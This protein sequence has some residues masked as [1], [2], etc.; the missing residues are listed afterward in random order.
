MTQHPL[1]RARVSAAAIGKV[2]RM[3]SGSLDDILTELLQNARRAGATTIAVSASSEPGPKIIIADNG[4]GIANPQALLSLGESDW[5][6][7]ATLREDPAGMGFFSLAGR[8]TTIISSTGGE[9]FRLAIPDDGWTGER[10]LCV[11]AA[12]RERG[13]TIVFAASEDWLRHLGGAI[14]RAS[15]YL[16]VAVTLDGVAQARKGFLDGAV[17]VK[18][19]GGLAIGVFPRSFATHEAQIN[20]HGLTIRHR[21]FSLVETDHSHWSA[22]I[23]IIDAPEL[24]L[25]LPARKELVENP[26]SLALDTLVKTAIFE[27]IRER[28]H[29]CLTK[30]D[31]DDAAALG[32]ELP[33]ADSLLTPWQPDMADEY[34]GVAR[35]NP[36]EPASD[37]LLVPC[38]DP[39]DAQMFHRALALAGDPPFAQLLDARPAYQGYRW[40]DALASISDCRA[41][42]SRDGDVLTPEAIKPLSDAANRIDDAM[43]DV[44]LSSGGVTHLSLDL[45]LADDPDCYGSAD[46]MIV[47]VTGST[48]LS[49]GELADYITNTGFSFCEDGDAGSYNDQRDHYEQAALHRAFECLKSGDERDLAKIVHDFKRHIGWLVP[50]GKALVLEYDG[51]TC[52][53]AFQASESLAGAAP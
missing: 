2:T 6:S 7:A 3:F 12:T 46:E 53:A 34:F 19:A 1:V 47:L 22:R 23:D 39:A 43:L 8:A 13:T 27:A 52:S 51:A 20:F 5:Q 16:P 31:W 25:V 50:K 10:E 32:V 4:K 49:P 11:E 28:G 38:F 14:E 24:Q 48:E 29:H 40:Y 36:V 33:E 21:I 45:Y 9:A 17:R 15:R 44:I 42:L 30:K 35:E 37:A 18:R 41:V 26:H